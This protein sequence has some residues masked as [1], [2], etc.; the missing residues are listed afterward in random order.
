MSRLPTPGSDNGVWG[1]VLNDYLAQSHAAD[2]ALKAGV[3]GATQLQASAVTNSKLDAATQSTLAAVAG[4]YAK[5]AGGIPESDLTAGVQADLARSNPSLPV[6]NVE[7]YGAVGDGT[8][9]DS[10]A[11]KA[12]W[13]ACVASVVA[14]N[15]GVV[16]FPRTATYVI[17]AD[18]LLTAGPN[19]Q[20]AMFPIPQVARDATHAKVIMAVAGPGDGASVRGWPGV[21]NN[22]LPVATSAVLLVTYA[23][24]KTW[25]ASLGH[26]SV[27]GAPD[28]DKSAGFS[29]VT[30]VHFTMSGLIV[31]QPPNPSMCSANLESCSTAT[32]RNCGFDVTG[33]PDSSPE[34]SNPTGWALALPRNNNNIVCV[35]DGITVWGY[36]AALGP[37]EHCDIR[38][39]TAVRCK[40]GVPFRRSFWHGGHIAWMTT[41]QCP[42][43]LAGYDPSLAQPIIDIPGDGTDPAILSI[44]FWGIEDY[45]SV[46]ETWM[47]PRNASSPRAHILDRNNKLRGRCHGYYAVVSTPSNAGRSSSLYVTGQGGAITDF[48]A[49]S[50]LDNTARAKADMTAGGNPPASA[51]PNAPTIGTATAGDASA[52]VAFTPSGSGQP[53]N[54]YTVTSTPG[55][56]TGTGSGSPVNV[57]G[58]T[59]GVAYTFSVHATNTA[60][61][62]A[63]SAASNS[64]TPVGVTTY[65]N[66]T[67]TRADSASSLGSAD[68]GQA[69]DVASGIWGIASNKGQYVSGGGFA[70]ADIESTQADGTVQCD[71]T[72]TAGGGEFGIIARWA[73]ANNFLMLDFGYD[74]GPGHWIAQLYKRVAGTFTPLGSPVDTGKTQ[75]AAWTAKMV[76]N[77]SSITCYVDTTV[78]VSLTDSAGI[79]NTK[80]GIVNASTPNVRYDNFKVTS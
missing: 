47:D 59:N 34:P 56:I 76:L 69:W 6:F 46:S 5:P 80:H 29:G 33:P 44:G 40:I 37:A 14:G 18:T 35:A 24:A 52:S 8:T 38:N 30:N 31:R 54:T 15:G 19:G 50:L 42:W 20:Y 28:V 41:E 2:G 77:G 9:N 17:S 65:V 3:V 71:L 48:Q 22:T 62:S 12:A 73:D 16:V 21:G 60:G 70:H 64:V 58:L 75:A 74:T 72:G 68:T 55:S 32:V 53:A 57:A 66:D 51:P 63:E 39:Y 4:K 10:V 11:V 45:A 67:F 78:L 13:D 7:T 49:V 1:E 23:S 43:H 79:T 26:P 27:I 36:Y 25:N 61:N